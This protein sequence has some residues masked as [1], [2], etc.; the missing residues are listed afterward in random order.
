MQLNVPDYFFIDDHCAD[1]EDPE[2]GPWSREALETM[3]ARFSERLE[4][5]FRLGLESRASAANEV[6][7]RPSS[8]PRWST[9][10]TREIQEA[11]WRSSAAS[12]VMAARG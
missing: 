2:P 10:L 4:E 3:N 12:V 7:L 6:K 9:P 5:A 11:L 1:P 8:G